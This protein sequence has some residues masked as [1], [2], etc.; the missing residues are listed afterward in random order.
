MCVYEVVCDSSVRG[1]EVR[2]AVDR[3]LAD[4]LA[5]DG[6]P[7]LPFLRAL[8]LAV[9]VQERSPAERAPAALAAQQVPGRGLTGGRMRS[10]RLAQYPVRAGSSGEAR[11]ATIVC[12]TIFVQANLRR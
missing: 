6:V 7:L 2:H 10:R 3:V 12:L 8:G 5:R 11:P 9:S 1:A 4:R